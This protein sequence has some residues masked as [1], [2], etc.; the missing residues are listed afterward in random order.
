MLKYIKIMVKDFI[1]LKNDYESLL[2]NQE[3][4][5]EKLQ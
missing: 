3:N 1:G 5:L 2:L 4:I